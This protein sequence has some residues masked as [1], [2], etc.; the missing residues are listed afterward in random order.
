MRLTFV[1]THRFR[2]SAKDVLSDDDL[3]D[4]GDL[5]LAR[6]AAGDLIPRTGGARKIRVPLGGR[7][8]SGGAHLL[9]PRLPQERGGQSERGGQA[10]DA[11]D[12]GPHQAGGVTMA[13]GRRR[14]TA[15]A[16]EYEAMLLAST[17]E[18]TA[19]DTEITP[20]PAY[21]AK[22]VA[23]LRKRLKLSQPVFAAALNVSA[24]TVRAWERGARVPDGPSLRLLEV[25]D[26]HP[27]DVL[28]HVHT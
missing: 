16:Q 21:T 10:T 6:P 11:G 27:D 15:G 20:P 2:V 17:R 25:A 7:G 22:R 13:R 1:E 26:R 19:R 3:R 5:L 9:P 14:G 18:R 8:K 12:V 24:S 4:L 23:Q 28:E